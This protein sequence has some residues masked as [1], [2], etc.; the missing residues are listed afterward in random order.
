LNKRSVTA[1]SGDSAI[2][3]HPRFVSRDDV[4]HAD[5]VAL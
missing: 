1:S 3:Q 5:R 4:V 2:I